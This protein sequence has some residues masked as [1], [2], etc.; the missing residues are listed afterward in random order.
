M[1]KKIYTTIFSICLFALPKKEQTTIYTEDFEGKYP[2]RTLNTF[3]L[4]SAS[5][6]NYWLVNQEYSGQ[7][8]VA[9]TTDQPGGIPGNP[10]S[11]YLHI[12]NS[13]MC[14]TFQ[15]CNAN[16][17]ASG[18]HSYFTRMDT[19]MHTTGF[20]GVS[21]TFSWLCEGDAVSYGAVYYRTSAAGAWT[22]LTSPTTGTTHFNLNSFAWNCDTITNVAFDNQAYL[23]F[24]FQF[25]FAGGNGSDPPFCVDHVVVY[26]SGTPAPAPVASF[27]TL[28]STGAGC[29]GDC[30]DFTSTSTNNPTSVAWSFPGGTPAN[31][32][33]TT[34]HVCFALQGTY[35]ITLIAT[36]ASGSDTIITLNAITINPAPPV[37][38]ITVVGNVLTANQVGVS[39]QWKINNANIGG[40]TA[41]SYTIT[42]SGYYQVMV[43]N[44][45]GCSNIS[46]ST[47]VTYVNG[48][49]EA[50]GNNSVS[51][52]PNPTNDKI[53]IHL[54][55]SAAISISISD[56]TGRIVYENL[57]VGKDFEIPCA[58]FANGIYIVKLSDRKETFETKILKQ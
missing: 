15:V 6:G 24:G 37:P 57:L 40:A 46:D 13:S 4:S 56:V 35:P 33:S 14:G 26:Y 47:F 38:T 2:G 44:Q 12:T 5:C 52:F 11:N 22:A 34:P 28:P 51:I 54:Q 49:N 32:T 10:E 43:T 27:S 30:F 8:F 58:D 25:K 50:F 55:N 23:Q 7:S 39:Y 9:D 41:Q 16:Y 45:Y 3:D 21:I 19:I 48:I 31:S 42:Q 53:N 20:G 18:S 36:N 17:L 1:N 29:P